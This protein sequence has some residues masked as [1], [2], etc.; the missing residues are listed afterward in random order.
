ML[1]NSFENQT[2]LAEWFEHRNH[3]SVVVTRHKDNKRTEYKIQKNDYV[4]DM[5][6][7]KGSV[8]ALVTCAKSLADN[9]PPT[10][11]TD[12]KDNPSCSIE[13]SDVAGVVES[14]GVAPLASDSSQLLY[15]PSVEG[16]ESGVNSHS[17]VQSPGNFQD[18]DSVIG[19]LAGEPSPVAVSAPT[20]SD[21]PFF[22]PGQTVIPSNTLFLPD[23][24]KLGCCLQFTVYDA[25]NQV[26]VSANYSRDSVIEVNLYSENPN[27]SSPLDQRLAIPYS[28]DVLNSLLTTRNP[29]R[30]WAIAQSFVSLSEA[31]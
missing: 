5:L 29:Q 22:K 7:V 12:N 23:N 10:T 1:I 9:F 16:S 18:A 8:T 15:P 27:Y 31:V 3:Y 14:V 4:Y 6:K 11:T 20:A 21:T 25:T 28:D 17:P 30:L 26:T 13:R 19:S 24:S 2:N